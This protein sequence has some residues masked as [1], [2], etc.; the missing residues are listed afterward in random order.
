MDRYFSIKYQ[1][2]SMI[3]KKLS[4]AR[5]MV[6]RTIF[7]AVPAVLYLV[8]ALILG[9]SRLI[10]GPKA[11]DSYHDMYSACL[12]TV[13][14]AFVFSVYQAVC[15]GLSAWYLKGFRRPREWGT[16]NDSLWN[17]VLL[18]ERNK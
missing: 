14:V 17:Q 18:E 7:S 13:V 11:R 2:D 4:P 3:D 9:T 8:C 12:G 1:R 6:I 15:T 10:L 16:P 5:V